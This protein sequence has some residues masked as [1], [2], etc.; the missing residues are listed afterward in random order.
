MISGHR[1]TRTAVIFLGICLIA[2][3]MTSCAAKKS[4][5]Q[6]ILLGT[7]SPVPDPDR[8]GP[9]LAVIVNNTSYLVDAGTGCVRQATKAYQ[10]M[11]I[12][13]LSVTNLN[14]LFLTHLHS[15]HTLGYADLI[16]TPWDHRKAPLQVYGPP[17]T[18]AMTNNLLN[19]YAIDIQV[20]ETGLQ[21]SDPKTLTPNVHTLRPGVIY[22]DDNVKVTAF[23][24]K[25]GTF[26]NSYGFKFKTP[27]RVIVI[28]GDTSFD[29]DIAKQAA[30][31]DL[32]VHEVYAMAKY[33]EVPEETKKYLKAFHTSTQEL[34][35]IADQ[36]RPK[37][38]VPIH[39][40]GYKGLAAGTIEKEIRQAGYKGRIAQSRDLSIF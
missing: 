21:E 8:S 11:G 19:A 14:T 36:A 13:P 12:D 33:N 40:L 4:G 1:F 5:T 10:D 34:A 31:A 37:L 6:V 9:A 35:K 18:Q 28:S 32:L 2:G 26:P 7:G 20:R 24:V 3:L 23:K 22:Q 30:G 27:D 39:M 29:E 38:L 17:G 16:L 25:H 15:D